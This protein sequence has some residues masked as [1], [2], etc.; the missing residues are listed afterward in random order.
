MTDPQRHATVADIYLSLGMPRIK[1]PQT[2]PDG[3][4][5]ALPSGVPLASDVPGGI[6]T[7]QEGHQ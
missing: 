4:A 3:I 1:T 7:P 5:P 2:T 6:T